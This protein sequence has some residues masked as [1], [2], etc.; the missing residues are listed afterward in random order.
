MIGDRKIFTVIEKD[1][2]RSAA[3]GQGTGT[4]FKDHGKTMQIEE[5]GPA[6]ETDKDRLVDIEAVE[7]A[8]VEAPV[9]AR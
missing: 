7:I 8:P 3:A 6:Y 5:V 1:W 2:L 4:T 9:I